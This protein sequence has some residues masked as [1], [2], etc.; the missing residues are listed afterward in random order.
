MQIC[1]YNHLFVPLSKHT[2]ML[3]TKGIF[4]WVTGIAVGL[5]LAVT[6]LPRLPL[7]QRWLANGAETA[8]EATLGTRVGVEKLY[9]G[10]NGRIVIDGLT[11]ADL[12]KEELLS[13]ARL[14]AR[15]E[16]KELLHGRIRIGN[17]QLFGVR[18]NIYQNKADTATNMQFLIDALSSKD[19]TESKPIDLRI[20]QILIRRADITWNQRWKPRKKGL[21]TAHLHIT[22][23]NANAQLNALTKDSLNLKVKRLEGC[24]DCGLCIQSLTFGL[25]SGR[26]GTRLSNFDLQLPNSQLSIPY[27]NAQGVVP[28]GGMDKLSY[29]GHAKAHV[30][31]KDLTLFVPKANEID[32]TADLNLYFNGTGDHLNITSLD[33]QDGNGNIGV[34]A[35]GTASNLTSGKDETEATV[36][37]QKLYI[38]N[39][40]LTKLSDNSIV[41]RIGDITANGLLS[42]SKQAVDANIKAET[43]VGQ[44]AVL[45]RGYT[46]G[47]IDAKVTGEKLDLG[48]LLD[49][50]ELGTATLHLNAKGKV[51]KQPNLTLTS[52]IQELEYKGYRYRNIA[53]DGKILNKKYQGKIRVKDENLSLLAEGC[54]DLPTFLIQGHADIASFNPNVLNLTKKYEA[55]DFSGQV[56]VNLQGRSIK[57]MTGT[58]QVNDFAMNNAEGTYHPGD[59][60]ITSK[61]TDDKQQIILISPF[62]EAQA[63]GNFN[64]KTLIE[65]VRQMVSNYL[66]T[67]KAEKGIDANSSD[68]GAFTIRA[69]NA[70]PLRRLFDIPVTF[71]SPVTAYGEIDIASSALWATLSAPDIQYGSEQ[72]RNV[73][74]RMESN[75]ESFI[76]SIQLQRL[77]K[78]KFV[79]FGADTQGFDKKMLTRLYWNNQGTP[80]Y[81]GDISI[82][83]HLWEGAQGKQGFEGTILPSNLI[84][85]DTLWSV[86]PG[87]MSY[88]D[89]VL[90]VDSF[91]ISKGDHFVRVEGKASKNEE[92]ILHAQLQN[93][94][95][96]YIFSLINF[97]AVELTGEAT[98]DAYAHSLFSSPHADAYLKIPQFALNY[99]TLGDLDIHLNW[100]DRPYSIYLDGHI[101][102]API[103]GQTL[104]QGYITPKKDIE[105]HGIDLHVNTQHANLYFLNKWTNAIFDNLQGRASGW[106]HIFGP[107]KG[108]NIEGDALVEEASLGIPSIGVRYHIVNDSV[109]MRPD[110]IYFTDARI[111]DPQGE[112]GKE[113]HSARVS[114]KLHHEHFNNLSFNVKVDGNNIL[115][116]DFRE[117]GDMPFYGTVYATGEVSLEGHSGYTRIGI[118]ATP[119]R[120]TSLTY[121]TT[122][123]DKLTETPFISYV[124]RRARM[125]NIEENKEE[126]EEVK[127]PSGDM[128]IDF[129][130]DITNEST[131]N[132][133]MDARSGDMISLN[134]NG[135]MLA[136]Y[137][138][139]GA[140]NL[141]GTYNIE[142]GTYGLSLQEVI[143]KRFDFS[144][145]GTIV[146]NGDPY[147]ADLNLQ[148][149]H[150]VSGVSLND[151]SAK[152][153]FSN[154][155]AR[156]NCL[157]NIG[158][159]AREPQISFDFDILNVNEDEKQMVRSLISTEEE[160]NM[161]VIYLLGIGRFYAYDYANEYQAQSSTAVNS[162]LS[163]T[164][165][166]TLNK[167]LS[168]IIGSNNW[169]FGAN[170]RT[171][172][173]GWNDMDVEGTLQGNLLNNRLLINGNF[174]YRN[175][176]VTTSSFIGDFDLK[177][178][179]TRSGSVA[180]KAYSETN[181]RYFTKSALTT[182]G[183]GVVL[184]KDF[185]NVRDLFTRHAK[186]NKSH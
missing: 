73:E 127:Q 136:H 156:V 82:V 79:N 176:T 2:D 155:S 103:G 31:T 12:Q 34:R 111:Y 72:L 170:L 3:R 102:D 63:E 15:M 177:Y 104:V 58:L 62:L 146:F 154:S 179:L 175:S 115:G 35:T 47:N 80:L 22:G 92:D 110:N 65:K 23:L 126:T 118:K 141:Y 8:L 51:S 100:G 84:V 144:N 173:D 54:F 164:L 113:E 153:S 159:K 96:E 90:K 158:G 112:P 11:M 1:V 120:R 137:Y 16:I 151:L 93:V 29:E 52:I 161:Q 178:L 152:G 168:N 78:G 49:K 171:G 134:G 138:N 125:Y 98:G 40:W 116:Y 6:V 61:K 142:R 147:D 28:F 129:D 184:K 105:Y 76:S 180:L 13:A 45:G 128:Y 30:S 101:Q 67:V 4:R 57:T 145:G 132:L 167:A 108:V 60:H 130:L 181:D 123:S 94:N 106:V 165:S 124:N 149:V 17:A 50:K 85:S 66:P 97:H 139:K 117:F 18:A 9:I 121:N 162:L 131:L 68:Y 89:D 166:G 37:I 99:A 88:Y 172:D 56:D 150:T 107:F 140:F 69:Y 41:S 44:M 55:T 53:F 163:S 133:L 19:N 24:E 81:A 27:L 182:Q 7:V 160:R 186:K 169:N 64:P 48:T 36:H 95:L 91:C 77:M 14:T 114:G 21:D 122:L 10:W 26:N 25:L 87:S 43:S 83:S 59:I 5:Y 46:N 185:S 42:W 183:V 109:Q 33:L 32:E 174:G 70:E 86:H 71:S 135:H 143:H 148:A 119:Q 20:N 39:S 157:M 74:M 75:Y 38:D